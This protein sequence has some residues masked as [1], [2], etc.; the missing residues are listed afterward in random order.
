VKLPV[1][2]HNGENGNTV[3][4]LHRQDSSD[5]AV[6]IEVEPREGAAVAS[7]ALWVEVLLGR[8]RRGATVS[9]STTGYVIKVPADRVAALARV[10]ATLTASDQEIHAAAEKLAATLTLRAGQPPAVARARLLRSLFGQAGVGSPWLAGGV[11]TTA[12]GLLTQAK[13][14][15]TSPAIR[16][17]TCVL[18]GTVVRPDVVLSHFEELCLPRQSRQGHGESGSAAGGTWVCLGG[19]ADP[20]QNAETRLALA[21]I[22]GWSGSR[23]HAA[24]RR[25]GVPAY[26]P[27]SALLRGPGMNYFLIESSTGG[28]G[29]FAEAATDVLATVRA[30]GLHHDEVDRAARWLIGSVLRQCSG[31]GRLF[32]FLLN[33]I[34]ERGTPAELVAMP[35]H[36]LTADMVSAAAVKLA[37]TPVITSIA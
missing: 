27:F 3:V 35:R 6:I 5:A 33:W 36:D 4:T 11:T 8:L 24:L 21:A 30:E 31:E 1:D 15:I 18:S 32:D 7:T 10:C 22:A 28:T 37:S 16:S 34:A 29:R 2:V 23:L 19:L 25:L 20:G 14:V 9:E 12:G 17:V 26:S 13:G